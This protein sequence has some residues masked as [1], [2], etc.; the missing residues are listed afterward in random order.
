[1]IVRIRE[2][3]T[4]IYGKQTSNL[5]PVPSSANWIDCSRTRAAHVRGLN[6][7]DRIECERESNAS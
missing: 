6:E 2:K 7:S 1:M 5:E 3:K 4:A